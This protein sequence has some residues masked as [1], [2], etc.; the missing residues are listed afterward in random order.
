MTV[1]LCYNVRLIIAAIWHPVTGV[2]YCKGYNRKIIP[3][4]DTQTADPGVGI[5]IPAPSHPFVEIDHEINSTAINPPSA[6][7]RRVVVSYKGKHHAVM[8]ALVNCLVKLAQEK[9]W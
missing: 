7:S 2:T 5:S 3:R 1:I 4:T 6:T 8:E 9:V